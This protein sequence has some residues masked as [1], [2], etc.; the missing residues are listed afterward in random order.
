MEQENETYEVIQEKNYGFRHLTPT[1][2]HAAIDAFYEKQYYELIEKGERGPDIRRLMQ[3]GAEAQEQRDWQEA[4]L[5]ADVCHSLQEAPGPKVLEV[6]CGTGDLLLHLRKKGF[7]V[8]GVEIAKAA[9]EFAR[10]RSL[11]VHHA[12]FEEYAQDQ[13]EKHDAI[14]L[15]NVLEQTRN[16][17]EV[18]AACYQVLR[19]GG[20]LI[21][22]SG[23]EFN[24]LQ[25]A[26]CKRFSM[27][28]WWVSTPDQ[29]NYFSFDSMQKI[30]EDHDFSVTDILSDFPMEMFLLMG[31]AYVNDPQIGQDCHQKRVQL[32][33]SL[34][35]EVRRNIYRSFAQAGIGRCMYLVARKS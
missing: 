28:P 3:G 18:I 32:E 21:L 6:G 31:L 10:E 2:S 13:E 4:T 9:V 23:N 34:E 5:Y 14:L 22:R 35:P 19:P 16:P 17:L 33:M 25:E 7:E 1:P 24:P 11:E 29:I 27:Q 20:L 30:L 15:M 8:Q 26:A 12:S